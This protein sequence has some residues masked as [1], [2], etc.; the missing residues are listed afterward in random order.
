MDLQA[1][2]PGRT[3][4]LEQVFR[5]LAFDQLIVGGSDSATARLLAAARQEQAQFRDGFYKIYADIR[6]SL[7]QEIAD[8]SGN[9]Y[10]RQSQV[11]A[12]QRLLDRLLFIYFCEDHPDK[13]LPKD[14]VKT[15]TSNAVR[16]PGASDT[17][18]Y[19][20]L[21]ALFHDLDVGA[22]TK[23]WKIPR[24]NGELFK[25]HPVVDQLS[26]S[27]DLYARQYI[28]TS[29]SGDRKVV[30]GC[31][32]LGEFDF[33]RELDRDLLGNLFERSIGDLEALAHGGRP[34][35]RQAF[36]IFYTASRLAKFVASSVVQT[37]LSENSAIADAL[38]G[39]ANSANSTRHEYI[40]RVVEL[41][42]EYKLADVACGSGVFLTAGLDALLAPYRK[43]LETVPVGGLAVEMLSF[44]QSDILKSSIFGVDILPQAVELAK[45][46]LWLTAARRNEPSADLS[47]NFLVGDS[48]K[49]SN[50]DRLL[51]GANSK[52]DLVMGNPPW[53]GEFNRDDAARVF[54]SMNLPCDGTEDSWEVFVALAISVLKPG[55]R[56]ALLV[57]D[58]FFSAD[59]KRIRKWLLE[60]CKLEKVYALGPDWF[61]A[62]VRMGTVV[63]QGANVIP[64][65][66][67]RIS[68]LALAGRNRKDAQSGARPLTQLE[69]GLA[70]SNFQEIAADDPDQKIRVLASAADIKLL[71]RIHH[72]SVALGELTYHGRGDEINAEGLIWRCGNC[73]AYTVPGEKS[74]GGSYKDKIC[75]NCNAIVTARD[76]APY[77]L[78]AEYHAAPYVAPFVDGH[79]LVHRYGRP[80]RRFMRVDVSPLIP[81]LKPVELFHGERIM[82]RQAGVGV[83]ATLVNDFS[84]CPQSVYLYWAKREVEQEGYTNEFILACLVS[85]TMNFIVMKSFGEIDPA[86][87]FAKLTHARIIPLPIPKLATAG[88]KSLAEE[89][90]RHVRVLLESQRLGGEDDQEIEKILRQLWGI[91]PNEGRYING[92]FSELPEGTAVQDLFPDGAPEAVRF[93]E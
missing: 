76:I 46:A 10:D 69:S 9:R 29:P 67:N 70:Q 60:R 59:K 48:L 5:L 42:Q 31:Y 58:T 25:T 66:E 11:L 57:P 86:R 27:D 13:L 62:S 26:L 6:A 23:L 39:V 14:L 28:W 56:F 40:T 51:A 92:F 55:G 4:S 73:M 49:S 41:L 83:V 84:R 12:V 75:P 22:D 17:K 35:A 79:A 30:H 52:F 72:E 3:E 61:T 8:W 20:Q 78:I 7:L 34:D 80:V 19:D 68:T 36:G 37:M 91:T 15:V 88:A 63:L 24:Y 85:R 65:R 90:T 89:V 82:I 21:K 33:W 18:A 93:P 71:A 50:I 47:D 77:S 54:D 43:A 38:R 87:A 53:G 2:A 64:G 16:S 32:G 74:K 81:A 1:D 44:R 45:L